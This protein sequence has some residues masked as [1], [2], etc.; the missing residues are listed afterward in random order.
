MSYDDLIFL[1]PLKLTIF[2]E[3][4]PESHD[5]TASISQR[6]LSQNRNAKIRRGFHHNL[7]CQRSYGN[8][9]EEIIGL[10]P[11]KLVRNHLNQLKTG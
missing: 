3:F 11:L 1:N 6:I 10:K 8:L 4:V 2:F 7:L 5:A 9:Q